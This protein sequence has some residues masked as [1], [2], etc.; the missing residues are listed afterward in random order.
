MRAVSSNRYAVSDVPRTLDHPV[1]VI[2]VLRAFTT[3]SWVLHRG[4][5]G[6]TL[7]ATREDALL[8]KA[9]LG[10]DAVALTD[11]EVSEG[12]DLGNSPGQVRDADLSGRPVVQVTTNGTVGVHAARHAPLVLAA[13]LVN[14][15]ATAQ[16][17]REGGHDH[18]NYVITGG[19]G[20]AEEDLACAD[21]VEA[22]LRGTSI[23]GDSAARVAAS[24][25]AADLRRLEPT[26]PG[27]HRDDVDLA[28]EVDRFD[29]A[30]VAVEVAG[31]I[32]LRAV[33]T[34]T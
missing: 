1:V 10:G 14:A 8:T 17:L 9:A 27:I 5:A 32:E 16:V 23:P 12:F 30:L 34:A 20:T 25:A 3:A 4:A 21:L 19:R 18:V 33:T 26:S 13:G 24:P 15:A 28:C 31:R 29:A 6:L 11:T 22:H 7:C 2:D